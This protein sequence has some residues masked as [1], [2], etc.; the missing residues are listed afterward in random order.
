MGCVIPNGGRH[1]RSLAL[2]LIALF[3][4]LPVFAAQYESTSRVVSGD[5]EEPPSIQEVA[6]DAEKALKA[7]KGNPYATSLLLQQL[8]A[9]AIK[10][11]DHGKAIGYYQRLLNEKTLAGPALQPVRYNL[12]QL[13]YAAG[14]Y[15]NAIAT[16]KEYLKEGGGATAE[17]WVLLG[18]AYVQLKQFDLAT[19]PLQSAIEQIDGGKQKPEHEDWFRLLL[20][21]YFNTN[22]DKAARQL[23]ERMTRNYPDKLEYWQQLASLQLKAKQRHQAL[24][25]VEM[26]YRFGLLQEESDLQQFVSLFASAGA[27]FYGANLLEGW[28]KDGS[29]PAHAEQYVQLAALWQQAR[30]A[31]K[32]AEALDQALAQ[33]GQGSWWLQLGQIRLDSRQWRQAEMALSTA[34]KL[35]G[36][37]RNADEAYLAL[38][39]ARYQQRNFNGARNAFTEAGKFKNSKTV[40]AQW[41]KYLDDIESHGFYASSAAAKDQAEQQFGTANVGNLYQRGGIAVQDDQAGGARENSAELTPVGAEAPANKD[42]SIPAWD[43]GFDPASLTSLHD[44][45]GALRNPYADE[46]PLFVITKDNVEQYA[47]ELAAGHQALFKT[48]PDYQMPVYPSHRSVR[49]PQAIYDATLKNQETAKLVGSDSLV[50]ATLGFPFRQPEHGAQVIW[51]HRVRYRGDSFSGHVTSVA[52]RTSGDWLKVISDVKVRFDYGNLENPGKSS[53]KNLL[54]YYFAKTLFPSQARGSM[55]LAHDTIDVDESARKIW[56]AGGGYKKI[57]R[58]PPI[59]YDFPSPGSEGLQF[60]DMIDMYNGAFNRYDWRLIGKRE[61]IIPYN[62][63]A[64]GDRGLSYQQL[65]GPEFLNPQYTRY[66]KHRVWVVDAVKRRGTS[67]HFRKRRFYIDEDSWGIVMVDGFN[68]TNRL[69]KF[70][71]GHTV[72]QYDIQ[73]ATTIPEIVYDLAEKRYFVTKLNNEEPPLEYNVPKLTSGWFSP[74]K[75][76]QRMK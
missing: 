60:V 5:I 56:A 44:A 69:W 67:H 2:V 71:E 63:Y 11:D 42:G 72:A 70:Q 17:S 74:T 76:K 33:K 62:A 24:A 30:Q 66:E 4:S 50:D 27:P 48:Y 52:Q 7:V 57:L 26:A 22:N 59:G 21:V 49:Y 29:L 39:L 32:A 43:G 8:A 20:A 61:M 6:Q 31:Q 58:I 64:L 55:V 75:L 47:A 15:K 23:L 3:G 73:A 46:V 10:A 1:I 28:I 34:I 18:G 65:L 68:A 25:S 35:G 54:I 41:L 45:N 9:H 53:G 12:A 51:N 40:A 37:G 14:K 36:L 38:G 16:M 13:Y 19:R